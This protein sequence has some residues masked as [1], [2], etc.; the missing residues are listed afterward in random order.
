MA[1]NHN[2]ASL[3][4]SFLGGMRGTFTAQL[5]AWAS[6]T[7]EDMEELFQNVVIGVAE[8]LIDRSPVGNPELWA[9]ND[10][11]VTYNRAVSDHNRDL[12]NDPTNL[13]ANGRLKPGRK[14]HDSMD[15]YKPAGYVGGHFRRNWQFGID[16]PPVGEIDGADPSGMSTLSAVRLGAQ[17]LEIGQTAYLV[18]NTPYALRLE[19]GWSKQAPYGMVRV[20]EAEFD[21][22]VREET[23]KL[24]ATR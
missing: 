23:L 10:L 15:V 6:Q 8:R 4:E 3:A 17:S 19:Y 20:T 1:S 24:V 16:Q 2:Q 14:L 21:Q 22:I 9:R 11:A 7:K 12:R 18:N 5:E 13:T